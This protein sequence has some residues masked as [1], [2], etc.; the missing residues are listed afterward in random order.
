MVGGGG[1]FVQS[2]ELVFFVLQVVV[3][4]AAQF[5]IGAGFV[6][7]AVPVEGYL[8]VLML[9]LGTCEITRDACGEA[10]YWARLSDL[11]KA[12]LQCGQMYGR[13]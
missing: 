1:V 12:L 7:A 13:S 10:T 11:E 8:S 3:A 2:A 5:A 9:F 6:R 4:V